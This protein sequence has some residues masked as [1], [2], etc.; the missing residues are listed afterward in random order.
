MTLEDYR[1]F[2][3][4]EIGYASNVQSQPL[5]AAF[6]R[7]PREQFLDP[8]RGGSHRPTWD[9]AWSM[10]PPGTPTHA[11]FITMCRWRSTPRAT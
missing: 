8:D 10:R 1:R 11:I 2:Y 9:L 5:L 3:A 4:E 7:V 6:A